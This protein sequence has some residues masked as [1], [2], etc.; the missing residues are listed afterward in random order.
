LLTGLGINQ[1]LAFYAKFRQHLHKVEVVSGVILVL[2][3]FLVMSGQ[4]TLLASSWVARWLPNAE[5]W[6]KVA[7]AANNGSAA[8]TAVNK[9]NFQPAPDVQFATLEGKPFRL[10]EARGRV[11]LLNFWATW[12]IP[13]REEIPILK[14]KASKLLAPL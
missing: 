7:P 11:V 10:S 5:G 1:F 8:N 13:C 4:S 14:P 3:G 9:E 6:I 12:C 2:V